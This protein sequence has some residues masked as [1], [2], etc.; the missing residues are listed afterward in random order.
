MKI[1]SLVTMV[2]LLAG[3]V[4]A[5]DVQ[6]ALA[7]KNI[8]VKIATYAGPTH[9]VS[10][11]IEYFKEGLE[12]ESNG[13]FTIQ[14]FPNNQLGSE[15]VFIDQVRRGTIQV[16]L[17]GSLIRKDEPRIGG[18]EAPF[19]IETWRQA[20]A[21]YLE[22]VG[23]EML[24]GDYTKKTNVH[25]KGYFVN[26][27]RVISSREPIESMEGLSKLKIRVPASDTFVKIFQALG[28]NVVMMP[29]GEV[30]NA[31]ETKVVDSQEN[32]Y[33]TLKAAGWWEVQHGVL[34]SRHLFSTSPFLVN[35]KF[36]EALSS[37]DKALF[38]KWVKLAI[39]HNWK[40]SEEDDNEAKTF[41]QEKGLKIVEPSPEFRQQMKEAL[42]DFYEWYYTT[43]PGS[44]DFVEYCA[45][46][47]K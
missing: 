14:H 12:K 45:Q 42:K 43:V 17:C 29:M 2:A 1:R 22:G 28:C 38:D 5:H 6:D 16:A 13:R 36:Y 23:G 15:D 3:V 9:P 34:E 20:R 33:P 21:V 7:A 47:P 24:A 26:G 25:I 11:S 18:M 44:K 46:Q 39:E 32:P 27:F 30:Y 4:F 35:G 40:I 37:E 31:L 8:A 19:A 41:L 10:R